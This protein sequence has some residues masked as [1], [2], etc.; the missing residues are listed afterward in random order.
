MEKTGIPANCDLAARPC[1]FALQSASRREF[2][3]PEMDLHRCKY[4]GRAGSIAPTGKLGANRRSSIASDSPAGQRARCTGVNDGGSKPGAAPRKNASARSLPERAERAYQ[5]RDHRAP[6]PLRL[7]C[8]L[9]N[10]P[11]VLKGEDDLSYRLSLIQVSGCFSNL[12][13][14]KCLVHYCPVLLLGGQSY[15]FIDVLRGA[16]RWNQKDVEPDNR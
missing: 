3:R 7:Q 4:R 14:R 9:L 8:Y 1:T 13:H 12:R 15:H 11:H 6:R 16:L 2:A 5:L 10:D